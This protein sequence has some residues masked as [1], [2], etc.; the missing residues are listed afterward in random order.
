MAFRFRHKERAD[1]KHSPAFADSHSTLLVAPD[2]DHR[3]SRAL[4][5]RQASCETHPHS[6]IDVTSPLHSLRIDRFAVNKRYRLVTSRNDQA[7][8][9]C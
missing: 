2:T 8:A 6:I 1:E 5:L 3:Q 4:L 7:Q 9:M